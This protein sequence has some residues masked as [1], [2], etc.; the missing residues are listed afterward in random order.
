MSIRVRFLEGARRTMI[1]RVTDAITEHKSVSVNTN[2]NAEFMLG[3]NIDMKSFGTRNR[4]LFETSS[5][6][7]VVFEA[8]GR[9]HAS[10]NR[11]VSRS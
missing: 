6:A 4:V 10:G 1:S 9:S 11:G 5:R 8:R 3:E 7:R 2:L